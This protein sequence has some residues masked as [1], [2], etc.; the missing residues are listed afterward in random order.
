MDWWIKVFA[1]IHE[2]LNSKINAGFGNDPATAALLQSACYITM[3]NISLFHFGVSGGGSNNSYTDIMKTAIRRQIDLNQK[4]TLPFI[5]EIDLVLL[6]KKK[7]KDQEHENIEKHWQD[8]Y[9]LDS[10]IDMRKIKNEASDYLHPTLS[11][12]II[13]TLNIEELAQYIYDWCGAKS[14]CIDS[15]IN[16][17]LQENSM[18]PEQQSFLR[19]RIQDLLAVDVQ[20]MLTFCDLFVSLI[21]NFDKI[22]K[23]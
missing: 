10:S 17:L 2:E 6:Y 5:K 11:I 13:P 18:T 3:R 20:N 7:I 1:K 8:V 9:S 4:I 23:I 19:K 22:K 14:D 16:G 21:G 15:F 12:R